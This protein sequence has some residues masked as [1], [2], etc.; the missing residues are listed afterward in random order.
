MEIR[1]LRLWCF[2]NLAEV[3]LHPIKCSVCHRYQAVL[4]ACSLR[5]D[6]ALLPNSDL[7]EVRHQDKCVKLLHSRMCFIAFIPQEDLSI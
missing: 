4:S 5:M 6:L 1:S 2:G 7:T 3:Y